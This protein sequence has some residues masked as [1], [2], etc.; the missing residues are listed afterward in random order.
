MLNLE[1]LDLTLTVFPN[2]K[3]IDGFELKKDIINHMVQLNKFTFNIR[4]C[5]QC[6]N[7]IDLP[8]N[9]DIQYTFR[10]FNDRIIS[11][12]D[13]FSMDEEGYCHIYSYPYKLN[14]YKNITNH[15]PGGIFE[16][17]R[18]VSLFDEH[19]FEHEFFLRIAQSFP[20]L[21]IL[22]LSNEK[23]QNNK[24]CRES[25]ND[26]QHLSIIKYSHLTKL[27]LFETHEDYVEQFLVDTK[28]SLTNGIYL[29]VNYQSLQ[30]VTYNFT[31]DDTRTNC[32]KVNHVSLYGQS[33]ISQHLKD[34]FPHATIV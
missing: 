18:E 31:R 34:Y 11:C 8:S 30:N 13:Y 5:I 23:P 20:L 9:E 25:K 24:Q 21:E 3:F 2:N 26:N 32:A 15:F 12:V 33:E 17:V 1:K 29:L 7:Q 16:C 19:P 28:M 22:T 10:D 4:S 6:S 27:N 14:F